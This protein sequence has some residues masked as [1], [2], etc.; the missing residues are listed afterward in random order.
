MFFVQVIVMSLVLQKSAILVGKGS[1][2]GELAIEVSS[3]LLVS[4]SAIDVSDLYVARCGVDGPAWVEGLACGQLAIL[5]HW[6]PQ[7]HL[8]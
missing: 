5:D 6:C 2:S 1:L 8:L 4:A 3:S 7:Q